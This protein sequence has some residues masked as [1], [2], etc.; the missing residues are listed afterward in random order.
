MHLIKYWLVLTLLALATL[1]SL[2]VLVQHGFQG[3]GIVAMFTTLLFAA[4]FFS[5]AL[6]MRSA[7][8]ATSLS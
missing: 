3:I 5:Y 7:R 6:T 4:V 2:A 1:V 8:R